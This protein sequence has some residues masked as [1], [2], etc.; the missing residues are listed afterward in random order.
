MFS[1]VLTIGLLLDRQR[2][3][4][5]LAHNCNSRRKIG[6]RD[7]SCE[8]TYCRVG[9]GAIPDNVQYTFNLSTYN[10]C[11]ICVYIYISALHYIVEVAPVQL[12]MPCSTAA[13]N[14]GGCSA[15]AKVTSKNEIV[16]ITRSKQL[17][18]GVKSKQPHDTTTK[19]SLCEWQPAK[20]VY[21]YI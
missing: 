16:T 18:Y 21:I 5:R 1:L 4:W 14:Q 19:N 11:M 6:T 13:S 20:C 7:D 9:W 10:I 8:A 3:H 17:Q 12:Y 2:C 15:G